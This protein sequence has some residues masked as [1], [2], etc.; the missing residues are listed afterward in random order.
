MMNA[1]NAIRLGC[2]NEHKRTKMCSMW[3]ST[4]SL[5]MY[6]MLLYNVSKGVFSILKDTN[7]EK[8]AICGYKPKTKVDKQRHRYNFHVWG[9][10]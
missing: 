1:K 4:P 6:T 9:F 8:C 3:S 5:Q 7:N 2:H 10:E